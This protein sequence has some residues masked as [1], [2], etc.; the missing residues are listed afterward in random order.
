MTV[1]LWRIA[2]ETPAY[3]ADDRSGEGARRTGGRWNR[4]GTPMVY[5]SSTRALA[6]LE[7]LVHLAGRA[8]P[9]N[10]Y[11]VEFEVTDEAWDRR[12]VADPAVLVGWDAEPA[13]LSSLDWGTRWQRSGERLLAEVPSLIVPE[14]SNVLVNPA[15]PDMRNVAARKV[16]RWD[17]DLRLGLTSH[18]ARDP[19]APA[20]GR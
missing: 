16:R 15:H 5:T 1:R 9:L 17:F 6:C 14:E 7:V 12:T 4:A 13:G 11:L 20:R 3:A 19:G 2:A 10:R 8:L 18:L